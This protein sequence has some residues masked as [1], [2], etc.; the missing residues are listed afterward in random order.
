M[1]HEIL[2]SAPLGMGTRYPRGSPVTRSN[3]G[4]ERTIGDCV[5]NGAFGP[6][7]VIPATGTKPLGSTKSRQDA[8]NQPG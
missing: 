3:G 5:G 2:Q 8:R 4:G 1:T 6:I 7:S